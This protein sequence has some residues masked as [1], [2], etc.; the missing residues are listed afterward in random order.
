M[1]TNTSEQEEQPKKRRWLRW[2]AEFS[3]MALILFA[4]F[5][6]R[7]HGMLEGEAPD[8]ELTAL[9]GKQVHLDNYRGKPVLL[10]FW[11]SWCPICELQQG[12][13][14]GVAKDWQTVTV[15]FKSGSQ[16]DVQRYV[17]RKNI[18]DWTTVLDNEGE[19]AAKYG[20]NGVPATFILDEEGVVRFR[21][22]GITTGWGLRA[23][24]WLADWLV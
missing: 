2:L 3:V 7:T 19:L 20:V 14:A 13:V 23:R 10:Y 8:F 6:W 1:D 9:N 11:A 4:V 16:E 22:V 15:A 12:M 21:E 5:S 24:L 17:E 18:T